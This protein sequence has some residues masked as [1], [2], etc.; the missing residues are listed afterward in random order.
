VN[1]AVLCQLKD[2]LTHLIEGYDKMIDIAKKERIYLVEVDSDK[3]A[4]VIQQKERVIDELLRTEESLKQLLDMH[5]V[6]SINEF[7]FF[8][9]ENNFVDDIRVLNGKLQEKI[10][11][12]RIKEEV[13]RMIATEHL[14]FFNGLLNIYANLITGENYNKNATRNIKANIMSVRA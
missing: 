12:F 10:K 5:N 3:M 9:S 8:A 13:N 1:D 7:L 6:D 2:I 14:K 4:E 11:E